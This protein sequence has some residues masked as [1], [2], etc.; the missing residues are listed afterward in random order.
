MS[1]LL[2]VGFNSA[3]LPVYHPVT[4]CI[5]FNSTCLSQDSAYSIPKLQQQ[6]INSVLYN[7]VILPTPLLNHAEDI[8][9]VLA[10]LFG[11]N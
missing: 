1:L 3:K 5:R 6:F 2:F 10:A 7:K 4:H 11:A 9:Y 8:F